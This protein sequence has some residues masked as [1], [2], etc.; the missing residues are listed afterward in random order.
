MAQTMR[1]AK[2]LVV[3]ALL[4]VGLTVGGVVLSRAGGSKSAS[5]AAPAN[6]HLNNISDGAAYATLNSLAAGMYIGRF[7]AALG[8]PVFV[9]D[10]KDG[11][12]IEKTFDGPGYLVQTIQDQAGTVELMAVT[13][14]RADFNPG[15][16]TAIGTVTL[17][18]STMGGQKLAGEKTQPPFTPRYFVSP[19]TAN[20]YVYDQYYLGN[21]GNY[22]NYIAGVD[23][24]CKSTAD[25]GALVKAVGLPNIG[26]LTGETAV[27]TPAVQAFRN[28]A[29]INTYAE[30]GP[31]NSNVDAIIEG[32][33]I[34]ADRI[35]VRTLPFSL[36][37]SRE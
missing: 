23:D 1:S 6:A 3:A 31:D 21:P 27:T 36:D 10:S 12:R 20:T 11:S 19:A 5:A 22:K 32:F 35:R 29:V 34:G 9:K 15:F 2:L 17:G 7:E 33:Q 8:V 18:V 16:A 26:K 37:P 25:Y 30:T 24:A 14:C 28:G 13:A 4:G